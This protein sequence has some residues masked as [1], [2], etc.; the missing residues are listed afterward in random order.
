M[1]F[2]QDPGEVHWNPQLTLN[3]EKLVRNPNPTFLGITYDRGL[4]FTEHT[5][6]VTERV[7][8]RN[9]LFR[10]LS[11][12]DWG[13]ELSQLRTIYQVF[14][15]PIIEYCSPAWQPWLSDT[16]FERLE[17]VQ[18]AAARQMTGL[19]KTT[20]NEAVLI[21]ANLTTV[22]TQSRRAA[23]IAW[24]KSI[25]LHIDNP[26]KIVT[27]N[28]PRDRLKRTTGWAS[29]SISMMQTMTHQGYMAEDICHIPPT[30]WKHIT[31]NSKTTFHTNFVKSDNQSHQNRTDEIIK[32]NEPVDYVIYTDGSAQHRIAK[33]G[34][35]ASS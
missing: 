26:R 6:R 17:R 32:E 7:N 9:N 20:P 34:S 24:E 27:E 8:R 15:R 22:K 4:N 12:S 5:K 13:W 21:E 18:R 2:T 29:Q 11:G 14:C 10:K 28:I 31:K 30:P 23:S 33:S 35:A 1:L 25:R 3:G 19:L 16:N